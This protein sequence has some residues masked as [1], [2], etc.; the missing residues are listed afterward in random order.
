M[1]VCSIETPMQKELGLF[2]TTDN[3]LLICAKNKCFVMRQDE[4]GIVLY[5]YV[6]L[7]RTHLFLKM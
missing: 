3:T 4:I 2:L 1:N 6:S 5:N 7:L